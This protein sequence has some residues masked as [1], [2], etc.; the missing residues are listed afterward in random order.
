MMVFPRS[1]MTP[2]A[3]STHPM[4][5]RPRRVLGRLH[6]PALASPGRFPGRLHP[7]ALAS[8]GRF[9]GPSDHSVTF[10]IATV[11]RGMPG[12]IVDE[13]V[14][15]FKYRPLLEAGFALMTDSNTDEAFSRSLS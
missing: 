11:S 2:A 5:T 13:T 7:P 10:P 12:P 8:P 1:L 9:L 14:T 4:G 3:P 6:P 15:D